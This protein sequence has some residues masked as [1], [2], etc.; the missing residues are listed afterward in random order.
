LRLKTALCVDGALIHYIEIN[1]CLARHV[2][3]CH[4]EN[5]HIISMKIKILKTSAVSKYSCFDYL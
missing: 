1:E 2:M 3:C 5:R 4:G